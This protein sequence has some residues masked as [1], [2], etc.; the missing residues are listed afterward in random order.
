MAFAL[1]CV[2]LGPTAL[3]QLTVGGPAVDA[4][5][6]VGAY[7]RMVLV[8]GADDVRQL[9]TAEADLLVEAPQTNT[10]TPP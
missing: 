5:V 2:R 6:A 8:V 9:A 1:Y 10:R 7:K 4:S 3:L